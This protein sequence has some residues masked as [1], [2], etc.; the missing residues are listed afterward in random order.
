MSLDLNK[1]YS[2]LPAVYRIRDAELAQHSGGM[3][4]PQEQV[5]L[6]DLLS[7]QGPLTA[8]EAER[9]QQLQDKSQRGPLKALIAILA[10]QVEVLEDSL[11]QAYDD[12][13]VET[14]QEWIV[15][16]IGDLVAVSGLHDFP[17][18]PFSNRAFVADALALRRRKGT[19]CVLEQLAQDVT[20]W[21]ANVVEYF[22]RLAT[23]QYMNHIRTTNL[24]LSDIRHADDQLLN[25]PFDPCARTLEVRNI[26]PLRGKYN[27][28]NIGVFLWRIA[29][30]TITHAPA[31]EMDPPNGLRF[32][33]DAIG[34]ETQLYTRART[35]T[36]ITQLSGPLNVPMAMSRRM[37]NL[38]VNAY[39][40]G[41]FNEHSIL[42]EY[43]L[44][45]TSP[46]INVTACDLSDVRDAGGHVIG[47]AHQPKNSIGI[48][49]KLGRIAFPSDV[50]SPKDV[51]VNYLYGFS[52]R[53]GGGEYGRQPDAGADVFIKIPDDVSTIQDRKSVV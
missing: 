2:L 29:G 53:M 45:A 24:T 12:Q 10:E 43:T 7:N 26:E 19:V 49:P 37:L 44:P 5:E 42:L 46:P 11:V 4:D 17:N 18:A 21:S 52:A 27:I 51:R 47:W 20:G 28:P 30:N 35:E 14:C 8:K 15:P 9:L 40:G 25:T 48:D 23:S 32:L 22:Q 3:L 6:N 34:R 16:Y 39:Y 36:Q 13:F 1:I 50:S 31:F 41:D 33:F 38:N